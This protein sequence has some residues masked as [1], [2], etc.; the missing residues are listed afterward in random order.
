MR[1]LLILVL[2]LCL[3]VSV[4]GCGETTTFPFLD[5]Q[6]MP[7]SGDAEVALD[8]VTGA[9]VGSSGAVVEDPTFVP[10]NSMTLLDF[11][12]L[13]YSSNT[14]GAP[15]DPA[16][17]LTDQFAS[18]GDSGR[19]GGRP[20]RPSSF[21]PTCPGTVVPGRTAPHRTSTPPGHG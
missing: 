1:R 19:S 2:S 6:I 21:L 3:V 10:V 8:A 15:A 17:V 4:A 5:E 20:V 13:P 14:F 7:A 9:S 11:E 12:G 16:S 18:A